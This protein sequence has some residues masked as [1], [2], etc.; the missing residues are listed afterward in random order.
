MK[1]SHLILCLL[2]L[3]ITFFGIHCSKV[4]SRIVSGRVF[5]E[6][7]GFP[8]ENAQVAAYEVFVPG[9]EKTIEIVNSDHEGKYEIRIQSYQTDRLQIV[10][11]KTSY[12]ISK[13]MRAFNGDEMNGIWDIP[14]DPIAYLR[15]HIKDTGNSSPNDFVEIKD[16]GD[17]YSLAHFGGLPNYDTSVCCAVVRGNQEIDYEFSVYHLDSGKKVYTGNYTKKIRVPAFQDTL[18]EIFY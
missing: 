9:D 7:T 1:Y 17:L 2:F 15:L 18:F 13:K 14:M 11:T 16:F 3:I 10:A 4:G 12:R 5:D 8:I 6:T